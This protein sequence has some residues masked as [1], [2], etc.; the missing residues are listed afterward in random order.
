MPSK[1]LEDFGE[2]TTLH[3]CQNICNAKHRTIRRFLWFVVLTAMIGAYSYLLF[4]SLKKYFLFESSFNIKKVRN[5]TLSFPSVSICDQ[6]LF[7][8]SYL[9]NSSQ[10][11]ILLKLHTDTN[12][13]ANETE[14]SGNWLR[15]IHLSEIMLEP[16]KRFHDTFI[17]CRVNNIKVN[18]RTIVEPTMSESTLCYTFYSFY[19]IQNIG[20]F[21]ATK[22]G[23]MNGLRKCFLLIF[24]FPP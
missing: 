18:C 24:Y 2:R 7:P 11:E 1:I 13:T 15:Q 6:N 16:L 4:L 20:Q 8:K 10:E 23:Y 22:P 9:H 19:T 3:G 12:L 17:N 14:E 5:N 21:N